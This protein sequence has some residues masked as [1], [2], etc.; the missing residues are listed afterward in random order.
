MY[1][2][3]ERCSSSRVFE[4]V[5]VVAV[6]DVVVNIVDHDPTGKLRCNLV[7]LLV[8]KNGDDER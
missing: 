4:K 8:D 6:G 5:I 2:L 3:L 1:E 7:V